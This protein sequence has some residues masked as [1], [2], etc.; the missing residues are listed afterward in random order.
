MSKLNQGGKQKRRCTENGVVKPCKMCKACG[1]EK[2][3]EKYMSKEK[4]GF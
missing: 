4:K 3:N 1:R 2:E